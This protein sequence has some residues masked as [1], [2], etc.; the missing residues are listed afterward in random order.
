MIARRSF[1]DGCN[2]DLPPLSRYATYARE[3]S[4]HNTPN[5]FG[6]WMIAETCGWILEQGG[7]AVMLER[8]AKKA[9]VL[10]DFLDGS[11]VWRGH[12]AR[13]SRSMMN[14]TFRARADGRGPTAAVEDA[15]IA[16]AEERGMSGLKGHR[17]VGGLRASIYN[18]FPEAGVRQL[19][20]LMRELES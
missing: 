10:Y 1:L 20:D 12:A 15:L 7:L 4:M 14:V 6:I 5:T 19:V 8:N 11:K 18:A 9:A 13:G 17:S 16:K 3:R 2:A